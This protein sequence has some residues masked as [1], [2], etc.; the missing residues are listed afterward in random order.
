MLNLKPPIESLPLGGSFSMMVILGVSLSEQHWELGVLRLSKL[1]GYLSFVDCGS[2]WQH[3]HELIIT[4]L[5]LG[6][7]RFGRELLLEADF[8]CAPRFISVASIR[9]S[10]WN[11]GLQV[12]EP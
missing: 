1:Y 6:V 4:E 5:G 2:V 10:L 11:L 12:Q 7:G 8:F 3:S 9:L